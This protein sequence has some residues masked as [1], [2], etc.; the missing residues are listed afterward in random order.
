VCD[1]AEA[2]TGT[3]ADCPTDLR[4]S[5][6]FACR[7][8][9]SSCDIAE[10]CDGVS[11]DCPSDSVQPGTTQCAPQTC[12]TGVTTP[13]SFCAGTTAT[14]NASGATIPC[15]GYQCVGPTCGSSCTT[16]TDCLAA[17]FCQPGGLCVP[18]HADG[19]ACT[20]AGSGYECTSGACT[21][22]YADND[23]DGFGAGVAVFSCG[24]TA[25]AGRSLN[26]TD[27]CDTDLNAFPGATA[28]QTTARIGCGGFDYNC[29]GASSL[30]FVQTN[31]CQ[32]S[33]CGV[34]CTGNPG[35]VATNPACG[36]AATYVTACMTQLCLPGS[37]T[38]CNPTIETRI[39]SCR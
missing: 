33:A 39:Q 11:V 29:D 21:A 13:A 18:R 36:T 24:A 35:W 27:C 38:R 1:L 28:Y 9:V 7:T 23:A 16:N 3:G 4:R 10:S 20:G 14:C 26:N 30:Q 25:P 8:A 34:A 37:S 15:N 22:S 5:P 32:L 12:T 2:C 19:Q 17:Y 31:A 6:G